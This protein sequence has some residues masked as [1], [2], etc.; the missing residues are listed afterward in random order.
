MV[1]FGIVC[2]ATALRAQRSPASGR[3]PDAGDDREALKWILEQTEGYRRAG[4]PHIGVYLADGSTDIFD[5]SDFER[6]QGKLPIGCR[7]GISLS[8]RQDGRHRRVGGIVDD[9]LR[10]LAN[11]RQLQQ[12]RIDSDHFTGEG[13]AYLAALPRLKTLSV[14]G[15]G[16]TDTGLEKLSTLTHL[17]VLD[18][19]RRHPLGRRILIGISE[20]Q[21]LE[22]LNI[23]I[24]TTGLAALAKLPKLRK[25]DFSIDLTP[26]N[27]RD[28]EKLQQVEE[29]SMMFDSDAE[30]ERYF[31]AVGK[32]KNLRT[33]EVYDPFDQS[34]LKR[35]AA[36][37]ALR[38]LTLG[39]TSN[40]PDTALSSEGLESLAALKQIHSLQYSGPLA[41]DLLLAIS[42]M[43][44]LRE[45]TLSCSGSTVEVSPQGWGRLK[46]LR[47]LNNLSISTD[48]YAWTVADARQLAGIRGLATLTL[49]LS[50]S[51]VDDEILV[52]VTKAPTI[53]DLTVSGAG[54]TE[55]GIASIAEMA[56]LEVLDLRGTFASD[57]G[58]AKLTPVKRLKSL[59]ISGDHRK[60]T[61]QAIEHVANIESLES[62]CLTCMDIEPLNLAPL[63]RLGRLRRLSLDGRQFQDQHL[64]AIEHCRNLEI[65]ELQST[66]V[67]SNGLAELK[68]SH[69]Q[70]RVTRNQD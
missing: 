69:P 45:I 53:R 59:S 52:E 37:P 51:T 56:N 24:E 70:L 11:L 41:D 22:E 27:A 34:A 8:P 31:G 65:L 66:M 19:T 17:K 26:D 47:F 35:L 38:E 30:S 55:L 13:L 12:L 50:G 2:L 48:D 28:L 16:M 1:L 7:L 36:A 60:L 29:I 21:D 14:N 33:I 20:L 67:S 6:T 61:R 4:R 5:Q 43:T 46:S 42:K 9:D 49:D 3:Q 40:G 64:A 54:V 62:L 18:V 32:L 63:A 39:L 25:L 23:G 58:I 10:K 44:E 68:S 57:D 15:R